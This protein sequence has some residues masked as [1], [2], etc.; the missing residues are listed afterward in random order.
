MIYSRAGRSFL[1]VAGCLSTALSRLA[2]IEPVDILVFSKDPVMLRPRVAVSETFNDNIFSQLRG[3]SDLITTLSP[4]LNLQVGRTGFNTISLD[5]A[6]NANF[7]ADRTDLNAGEHSF[8]LRTRLQGSRLILNGTDRVQLLSSPVG[9]IEVFTSV[10]SG[11]AT[12]PVGGG[13]GGAPGVGGETTGSPAI[14]DT[15]G[16]PRAGEVLTTEERNV[17]RMVF[18]DAYSL[19]YRIG[20]KTGAYLQGAHSTT[21]YESGIRNLYD[22]NTLRATVGFGYQA[23]PKTSFFGELYYGQTATTPNFDAPKNPHVSFIGGFLG[24]RGQFTEKL[25]GVA[26]A[27]YESREF[28]DNSPTPSAPVVNVSLNHRLSQKTSITLDYT[29]LNEV[30]IQ[31]A[32][33]SYTADVVS[34]QLS[35]MLG[36]NGKW[37][38]SLGGSYNR[39][40]YEGGSTPYNR[41]SANFNLAYQVQL[42]LSASLGYSYDRIEYVAVGSSG[43]DINRVTLGLAV[44]Y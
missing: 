28:S 30:S 20:E 37:R 6:L 21:D 3:T 15:S 42:W 31:F 18:A 39:F 41:Y 32:R 26:K 27:G 36:S 34:A 43:Y 35:Q 33:E 11:P 4:G 9:L 24:V 13:E 16:P 29:R 12:P 38:A 22:I 8:D 7:Y 1:A 25:S 14:G 23:F 17:D 40:E 2:A 5:Y 10:P 44:G 19:G